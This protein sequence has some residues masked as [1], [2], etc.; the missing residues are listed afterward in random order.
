LGFYVCCCGT[1]IINPDGDI[2]H[3]K[4]SQPD[5]GCNIDEV[6]R[7]VESYQIARARRGLPGQW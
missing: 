7:L 4:F 5:V 3:L 1:A 2:Q 6:L